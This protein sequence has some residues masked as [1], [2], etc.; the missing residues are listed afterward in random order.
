M[1]KPLLVV[2]C[3]IGTRSGYGERSRDFVRALIALDKYD[4]KIISTRW[5]STPMNALTDNDTDLLSRIITQLTQQPD[6]FIQITVP[7]E[8]QRVGKFNIG[9]TAGIETTV[10]DPSWLEGCNR[11]DLILTS[12]EH[13]K[14]VFLDTVY[15]KKD[16]Q[17]GQS[18]GMLKLEKPI[19][20]LFEGIRLDKFQ[21]GYTKQPAIEEIFSG[22]KEDFCFLFVGHWYTRAIVPLTLQTAAHRALDGMESSRWSFSFKLSQRT[23]GLWGRRHLDSIRPAG[24]FRCVESL[25]R[26]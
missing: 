21:K 5:G 2:Q 15:E 22:I 18:L 1:N 4:V 10:C 3:P 13:S 8:F 24:V 25:S 26:R 17:S 19:E 12:S 20:V 6:I 9:L 7:N 16:Q 23:E 11:M 14:K